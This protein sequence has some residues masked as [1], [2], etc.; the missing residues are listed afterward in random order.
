MIFIYMMAVRAHQV[1]EK[2]G[3]GTY[4]VPLKEVFFS[5]TLK[6]FGTFQ[7]VKKTCKAI[8]YIYMPNCEN[9]IEA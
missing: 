8:N 9:I 2:V 3:E 7:M 6:L 1:N 4:R 5:L